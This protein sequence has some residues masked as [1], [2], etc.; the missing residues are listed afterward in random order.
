MFNLEVWEFDLLDC[1]SNPTL[2]GPEERGSHPR[3][4]RLGRR[5]RET[6]RSSS[7]WV[8]VGQNPRVLRPGGHGGKSQR[9]IGQVED[10][11]GPSGG[12]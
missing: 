7:P 1:H 6:F 9:F 10:G 8:R 11:R 3:V 2:K 12:S 5:R 4:L